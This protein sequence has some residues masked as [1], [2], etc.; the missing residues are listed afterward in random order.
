MRMRQMFLCLMALTLCLTFSSCNHKGCNRTADD[1][2]KLGFF[3]AALNWLQSEETLKTGDD[4]E[5]SY[6]T[7]EDE[8]GNLRP[9]QVMSV[10]KL[11]DAK[12][13]NT[14]ESISAGDFVMVW[15]KGLFTYLIKCDNDLTFQ[16]RIEKARKWCAEKLGYPVYANK[17]Y[18]AYRYPRVM[19]VQ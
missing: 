9:V 16:E 12:Y 6:T 15:K 7:E 19:R 13:A 1:E 11:A 14:R 4:F 8:N 5:T 10:Q 2:Q 3:D 18:L 17:N